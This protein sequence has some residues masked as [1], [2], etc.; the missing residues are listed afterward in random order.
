VAKL[1]CHIF[2]ALASVVA[3]CSP[4]TS[5]FQPVQAVRVASAWAAGI[6][7]FNTQLTKDKRKRILLS[8]AI[9]APVSLGSAH[10]TV[11]A[12]HSGTN[13][14]LFA[15]QVQPLSPLGQLINVT[16]DAAKRCDEKKG[17][18]QKKLEL[19]L[20]TLNRY[21]HAVDVLIQQHPDTTALAWGAIRMLV[22]VSNAHFLDI[23]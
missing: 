14:T 3:D 12:P 10:V 19:I 7:I 23:S 4:W 2:D 6:R 1:I 13:A 16:Q 21:A 20:S 17:A 15:T 9:A 8:N 11:V 18:I 5:R 22:T